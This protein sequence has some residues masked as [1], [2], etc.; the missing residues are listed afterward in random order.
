MESA[1]QRRRGRTER[2]PRRQPFRLSDSKL[3]APLSR[4]GIVARTSLLGRV[5]GAV[6]P[7]L[8][9]VVAPAG[10]GKTTLLAQWADSKRPRAA[11]LS[12][13]P[14]DNDPAVLLAYVAAAMDRVERI[15]PA[16][17]RALAAPS[18][19][20]TGLPM[21]ASALR[22]M[23]EPIFLVLDHAEV[24]TN[25]ECLDI[26]TELSLSVPAGSQLAIA[27][28]RELP[29]P[30]ARL[31]A[32]GRILEVGA[33]ELAMDEEEASRLLRE[34]G[35]DLHRHEV[36]DLVERTEGWPAGLYLAALAVNAGSPRAEAVWS[37]TGD[38]RYMGD[39]LRSEFLDRVS[40]AEVSFLT[41]TSVLER[42]CGPLCDA[43][44]N[45]RGADRM[46]EE[47]DSRN[48]LVVPL[49]RRRHWYRYHQLFR[50]LLH[51]E[52]TRRE[53][54]MIPDLHLRAAAWF[55]ANGRPEAAIEHAQ[56]AGDATWVAQ[57]VLKWMQPVWA[58]GRVDTVLG[59]MAW[60]EDKTWV[61]HYAALAAHGALI[62]ALL[63]R[64]GQAERWAAAAEG[65]D[66][67]GVLSDGDATKGLLAYLSALLCRQGVPQMR[68][69]AQIAWDGLDPASPYRA[70]MLQTEGISYLVEGDP[71]RADPILARAVDVA[72]A[73]GAQPVVALLL[74]ERA[75]AAMDRGDWSPAETLINRA[76]GIVSDGQFERY[77]TSALV[78][79]C[80]ARVSAHRGAVA[81]ARQYAASAARLRPLLTYALPVVSI[82]AL[83]ELG[84]AYLAVGDSG[85]ARAVLRQVQDIF[86][87]RPDL[88]VLPQQAA[89]LRAEVGSG[90]GQLG[91]ASSLTTA[92]LRLLP[93]LATHLTLKEISERLY[94]S[95]N[96][97]KTQ[98]AAIY[99]KFS[100]T[101][102]SEA[103]A[104][105]HHLGLLNHEPP[106]RA[107]DQAV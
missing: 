46:L 56:S 74:A 10:Y 90:A 25:R 44:L 53:P 15:A 57:L 59:W 58:S 19:S 1:V 60:L 102:R 87:Q 92:E 91:G 97:V 13:D 104:R 27:S 66:S 105:M 73:V 5:N 70:T 106:Q 30:A 78:F 3:Q 86:Q 35:V 89:E 47:L 41:R 4:P 61:E 85:G 26:V 84:R 42:M 23:A 6:A 95:R 99:R 22:S 62:H 48:L 11:W 98:A 9:C 63:G 39:Y 96:T 82:Q 67:S 107:A 29:L 81:V 28:R 14:H 75:L 51:A 71:G 17:F 69:D 49:D 24:I 34:A 37:F 79:A 100:V 103:L 20:E 55:E 36:R 16:V 65:A 68:R 7:T 43:T 21:L 45:T 2:I 8:I 33:S 50:Q 64:P 32:E 38:D 52:L 93:L 72:T 31:R 12:A 80:A 54:E 18:P 83:L 88:G 94:V 40:R 77:W 76:L 101:S